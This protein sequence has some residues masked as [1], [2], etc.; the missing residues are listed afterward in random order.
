MIA[1]MA[2]RTDFCPFAR[3]IAQ[4]KEP[5]VAGDSPAGGQRSRAVWNIADQALS[6][7]SNAAMSIVVA[8]L[9]TE[10]DFGRFALAFSVFSFT[11][12]LAKAATATPYVIASTSVGHLLARRRG[13]D[14]AGLAT[15]IGLA[16]GLICIAFALLVPTQYSPALLAMGAVLP[17][18]F[19]QDF[20]RSALIARGR[21]D[22]A[23]MNDLLWVV[24]QVACFVG[25]ITLGRRDPVTFILAWGLPGW[26]A[27]G[28][29]V[30][31]WTRGPRFGGVHHYWRE[32]LGN[33]RFLISEYV[34]VMGSI[35]VAS[36]L[37]PMVTSAAVVGAIR[38]S[39]TLLGPLNIFSFA[40]STFALTELLRHGTPTGKRATRTALLVTAVLLAIDLVWGLILIFLPAAWGNQVLGA[41]WSGTS[42]IMLPMVLNTVF[43]A[44]ST[45]PIAAMRALSDT[46]RTFRVYVAFGPTL[47][48]M[49]VLGGALWGAQGA[50]WGYGLSAMLFAPVWWIA[51]RRSVR[52]HEAGAVG[53]ELTAAGGDVP[54]TQAQGAS[55][56]R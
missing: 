53:A 22:G 43:V 31:Q 16:S 52:A 48:V 32:T 36:L 55:P 25:A 28:Y 51:L 1:C 56:D 15:L 2:G 7:L 54:S 20:W 49:A 17:G 14:A 12:G 44:M 45:G 19:L 13:A 33:A 24:L 35:Q 5:V 26:I 34:A 50:G 47:L 27:A 30:F 18:L 41:T 10:D 8:K 42:A 46:R 9:T 40:L 38:G 39:M 3:D 29:G 21:P 11:S 37:L 6:S 4:E 23:T